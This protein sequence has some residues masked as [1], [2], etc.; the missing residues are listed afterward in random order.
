MSKLTRAQK[1][2][3]KRC[4]IDCTVRRLTFAE[5]QQY[6]KERL[7]IDISTD[8]LS[9]VRSSLRRDSQK[10]LNVYH[11]DRFAFIDEV[12]FKRVKEYENYQNILQNIIANNADKPEVQI[13]AV[14][15]LNDITVSLTNMFQD[16]PYITRLGVD[17]FF[18]PPIAA[19]TSP[20]SSDVN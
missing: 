7:Q 8:Y 13:K 18:P 12:F 11:K 10:L 1:E 16:L 17:A 6:I 20:E 4:I 14:A 3:L 19:A 5:M 2:Q 15:E 9:H